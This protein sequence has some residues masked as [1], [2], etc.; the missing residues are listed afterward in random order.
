[1]PR[2][3]NYEMYLDTSAGVAF[4][5]FA[6]MRDKDTA[7]RVMVGRHDLTTEEK[8]AASNHYKCVVAEEDG[9]AFFDVYAVTEADRLM[10]SRTHMYT[11]REFLAVPDES[12]LID[13]NGMTRI[14]KHRM[15]RKCR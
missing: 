7:R 5:M 13:K 9:D 1:M 12:A 10:V 6:V 11:D 14:G 2:V 3:A 4:N 15:S 8:V